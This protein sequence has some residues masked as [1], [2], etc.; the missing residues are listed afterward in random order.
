[1]MILQ[2]TDEIVFLSYVLL[3]ALNFKLQYAGLSL[4]YVRPFT[5]ANSFVPS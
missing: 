2:G 1:M 3:Q 5:L 4:P